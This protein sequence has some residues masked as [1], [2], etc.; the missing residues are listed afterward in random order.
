MLSSSA[1]LLSFVSLCSAQLSLDIYYESLCPDSTRFIS[2]QLGP[3]YEALG[4][5]VNVNFNPYGFAEVKA[6]L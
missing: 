5:D 4:S 2:H 6:D 3:M 1:L